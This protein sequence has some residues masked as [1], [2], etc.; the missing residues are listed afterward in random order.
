MSNTKYCT[1]ANIVADLHPQQLAHSISPNKH[2]QVVQCL[3]L[4]RYS[5]FYPILNL[6]VGVY[7]GFRHSS[8]C[9][10][11][12]WN[13]RMRVYAHTLKWCILASNVRNIRAYGAYGAYGVCTYMY[14]RHNP[15]YLVSCPSM[16]GLHW[17]LLSS[18]G[19]LLSRATIADASTH[20][21]I[22]RLEADCM[23]PP[24]LKVS[25]IYVV[26]RTWLQA[27]VPVQIEEFRIFPTVLWV[28]LRE[29]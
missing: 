28:L 13:V 20:V 16:K 29:N 12:I 9:Y 5:P 3:D 10:V 17:Y 21:H 4:L 25:M 1:P 7:L 6:C 14:A 8:V 19:R 15:T 18:L 27:V 23:F 24:F 26:S 22:C 11:M 2:A